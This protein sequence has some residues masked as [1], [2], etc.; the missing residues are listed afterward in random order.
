M[1]SR[2]EKAED[3]MHTS[4]LNMMRFHEESHRLHYQVAEFLFQMQSITS[5]DDIELDQ[6]HDETEPPVIE[7][8]MLEKGKS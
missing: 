6:G 5:T 3:D 4:N 8:C 7:V 1:H 2:L